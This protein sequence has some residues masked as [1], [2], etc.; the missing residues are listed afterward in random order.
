MPTGQLLA[1]TWRPVRV[2]RRRQGAG[3]KG[4][5]PRLILASP[6]DMRQRR[7]MCFVVTLGR[8]VLPAA[9]P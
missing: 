7:E 4:A 8:V 9:R 1:A 5:R 6:G 2:P 3:I